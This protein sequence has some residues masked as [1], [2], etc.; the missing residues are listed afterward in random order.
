MWQVYHVKNPVGHLKGMDEKLTDDEDDRVRTCVLDD[1]VKEGGKV[2][3]TT[4]QDCRDCAKTVAGRGGQVCKCAVLSGG[5]AAVAIGWG[6]QD[7]NGDGEIQPEEKYWLIRNSWG[8]EVG[9]EGTGIFKYVRGINFAGIEEEAG[10]AMPYDVR[11]NWEDAMFPKISRCLKVAN[12]DNMEAK[13]DVDKCLVSNIC[14]EWIVGRFVSGGSMYHAG[15]SEK[16]RSCTHS[17]TPPASSFEYLIKPKSGFFV[18]EVNNE[19]YAAAPVQRKTQKRPAAPPMKLLAPRKKA[20]PRA[21]LAGFHF[22]AALWWSK[23]S[24]VRRPQELRGLMV[25]ASR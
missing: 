17:T 7:D 4:Y 9:G 10:L 19:R 20:R 8:P 13:Q 12:G 25:Q 16:P 22:P 23:R 21:T 15:S 5:H 2:S 6:H 3:C 24:W 11:V 1:V 14:D 18:I